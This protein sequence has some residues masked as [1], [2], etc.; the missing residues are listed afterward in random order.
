MDCALIKDGIVENRIVA[1]PAVDKVVGYTL[2]PL[3]ER[4]LV[5]PGWLQTATGFKPAPGMLPG[6]L[7]ELVQQ[8]NTQITYRMTFFYAGAEMLEHSHDDVQHSIR[9]EAGSFLVT[10]GG[11][12]TK[13]KVGDVVTLPIGIAHSFK[14][15]ED[16]SVL[17][18]IFP[19]K[20]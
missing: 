12:T 14:A 3:P 9:I 1:D 8:D 2:V 6:F 15:I 16:D 10:V 13:A 5:A 20:T 7:V 17:L 18:N 11:Q 4:S 19:V